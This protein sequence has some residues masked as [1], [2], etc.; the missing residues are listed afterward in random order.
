MPV[1][2]DGE[3]DLLP[4]T[5]RFR[6]VGLIVNE[7]VTNAAKHGQGRI[8]V[9][10][11]RDG[12][13]GYALQVFD[14]GDALPDGFDPMERSGLGMR[15]IKSLT[16]QLGGEFVVAPSDDRARSIF[17]VRFPRSQDAEPQ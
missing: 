14:E 11:D 17:T 8:T 16:A 3:H 15:V 2:V 7:L 1:E 13:D 6:S 4:T 5:I 10:F 9:A 12:P